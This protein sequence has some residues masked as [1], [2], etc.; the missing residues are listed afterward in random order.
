MNENICVVCYQNRVFLP[1]ST[2]LDNVLSVEEM[3][4]YFKKA[5]SVSSKWS[6]CTWSAG[7]LWD[8]KVMEGR[9]VDTDKNVPYPLHP[10][11]ALKVK[12]GM[13]TF[14]NI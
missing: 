10:T 13:F 4:G 12:D 11:N 5:K 14:G 9:R 7:D 3:E 8:D 2:T 6:N 1:F